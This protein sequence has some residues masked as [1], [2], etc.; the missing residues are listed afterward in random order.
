M[1]DEARFMLSHLARKDNES[2][3]FNGS[4]AR[5]VD[6]H[7]CEQHL[8]RVPPWSRLDGPASVRQT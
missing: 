1:I 5:Y 3:F 2:F 8:V 4:G 6:R 7:C